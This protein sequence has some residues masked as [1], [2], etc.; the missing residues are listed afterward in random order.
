MVPP[1]VHLTTAHIAAVPDP[2]ADISDKTMR[3]Y[4]VYK[5]TIS[6][7]ASSSADI[8]RAT[9]ALQEQRQDAYDREHALYH[10]MQE[11]Q[12]ALM[13]IAAARDSYDSDE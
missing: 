13:A 9:R 6:D 2:Y 1:A 5:A 12:E 3:A 11:Q 7:H 10:R 4:R 8:D